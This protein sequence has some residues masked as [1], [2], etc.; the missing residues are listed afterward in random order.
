[1]TSSTHH[2]VEGEKKAIP[3]RGKYG[4]ELKARVSAQHHPK[5]RLLH[6]LSKHFPIHFCIIVC[7][8]ERKHSIMRETYGQRL[9]PVEHL[10]DESSETNGRDNTG[11]GLL[12]TGSR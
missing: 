9:T 12:G 1:L 11:K 3:A 7:G 5:F 8:S 2:A 10:Q 6:P 4:Q